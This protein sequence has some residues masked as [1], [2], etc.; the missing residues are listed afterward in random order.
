MEQMLIANTKHLRRPT[1]FGIKKVLR[2]IFAL[3]QVVKTLTDDEQESEFDHAKEYFSLFFLT[4]QV[5]NHL[6]S[7]FTI[8][9]SPQEMLDRIRNKQTFT[10]GDYETMLNLQ[11]S[12]DQGEAADRNYSL[13]LLDLQCLDMARM[14]ES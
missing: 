7:C 12:V 9:N 3:Q 4:P 1:A 2:N 13:Y 11:C 5:R 8:H 6:L 10:F 14:N